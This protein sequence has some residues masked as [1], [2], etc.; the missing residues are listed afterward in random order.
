MEERDL[1]FA[2]ALLY[3]AF[4]LMTQASP[5][6]KRR[7]REKD[8]QIEFLLE[9]AVDAARGQTKKVERTS[10]TTESSSAESSSIES[11]STESSSTESSST[12]SSSTNPVPSLASYPSGI[13]DVSGSKTAARAFENYTGTVIAYEDLKIKEKIGHGGFG[14]VHL[15]QWKATAVGSKPEKWNGNFQ[16]CLPIEIKEPELIEITNCISVF[17][18][19]SVLGTALSLDECSGDSSRGKDE[20]SGK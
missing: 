4:D 8:R 2:V 20:K 5:P 18:F 10:A 16:I 3:G 15:A 1:P 19:I 13:P 14:D 6:S 17:H 11:S 7:R 9:K 12:E